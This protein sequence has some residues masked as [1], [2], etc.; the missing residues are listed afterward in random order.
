MIATMDCLSMEGSGMP[1][2]WRESHSLP[3]ETFLLSSQGMA[4][5]PP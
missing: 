3:L 4:T 5:S 1:D 2:D